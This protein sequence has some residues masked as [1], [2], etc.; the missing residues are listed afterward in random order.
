MATA[1]NMELQA[2]IENTK[3]EIEKVKSKVDQYSRNRAPK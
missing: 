1:E 2:E 3:Q